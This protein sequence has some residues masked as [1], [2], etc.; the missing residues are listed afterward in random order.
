[1]KRNCA[2]CYEEVKGICNL[3]GI[4]LSRPDLSLCDNHAFTTEV[5]EYCGERREYCECEEN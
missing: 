5:C 3:H 2:N 4:K 1:M